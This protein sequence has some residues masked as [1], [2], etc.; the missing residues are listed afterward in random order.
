MIT[1]GPLALRLVALSEWV[2][3]GNVGRDPEAQLWGRCAKVAEESGEVIAA[4]IGAT[5]QN[6]RKGVTHTHEDLIKELLDVAVSALGAVE[7]ITEHDASSIYRLADHLA[8]LCDRAG[9][10]IANQPGDQMTHV[11]DREDLLWLTG[12]LEGEG[13]F[14]AH[15]GRYP[16]I[17]L[18]MVDRDVVGRAATLMGANVRLTLHPAPRKATWHAEI[19]GERAAELM[20]QVLPLMGARRSAKIAEVLGHSAGARTPGPR[21]ERPPGLPL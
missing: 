9:L 21:I 7:H 20:R 10:P 1:L 17:R 14:D 8:A 3:A 16:R 2:D 5:G 19:Q 15:R 18:E 11:A 6:P 12:I 13:C 4:L